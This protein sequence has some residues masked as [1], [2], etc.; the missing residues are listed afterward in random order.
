MAPV[1]IVFGREKFGLSNAEIDRCQH[2][3]TIPSNPDYPSLNLGAAVQ[4]MAYEILMASGEAQPLP[5]EDK[6]PPASCDD[7][8]LFFAHMEE[9]LI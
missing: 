2:L 8:E 1:A 9:T 4:L 3:V 5:L 6:H 7:M